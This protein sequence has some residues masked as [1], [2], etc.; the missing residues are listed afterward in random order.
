MKAKILA[1]YLDLEKKS[2]LKSKD[3]EPKGLLII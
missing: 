2:E 3:D 1:K